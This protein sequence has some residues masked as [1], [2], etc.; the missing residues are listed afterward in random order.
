VKAAKYRSQPISSRVTEACENLSR[1]KLQLSDTLGRLIA[2]SEII[3]ASRI[4]IGD[5]RPGG[6]SVLRDTPSGCALRA[7]L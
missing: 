3:A 6:I 5:F 4:A 1:H 7:D 2:V